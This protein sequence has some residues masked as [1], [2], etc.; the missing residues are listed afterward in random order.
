M[1]RGAHEAA[2]RAKNGMDSLKE[3][4]ERLG[5]RAAEKGREVKE[6]VSGRQGT[7]QG[8]AVNLSSPP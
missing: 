6:A 1:S 2:E 4:A 3:G 7:S 8:D 5:Q